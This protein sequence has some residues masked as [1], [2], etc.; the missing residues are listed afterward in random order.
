MVGPRRSHSRGRS[1]TG[2][3]RTSYKV[4]A[5]RPLPKGTVIT[6]KVPNPKK[7]TIKKVTK[8]PKIR[9][10]KT[11]HKNAGYH[12]IRETKVT[13]NKT[14]KRLG[15]PVYGTPSPSGKVTKEWHVRVNED[16]LIVYDWK[17][18]KYVNIGGKSSTA[19]K[20]A[21]LLNDYLKS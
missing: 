7:T 21:K 18:S 16:V 10:L 8:Q 2:S 12:L 14:R 17:G 9:N 5:N 11:P 3:S 20:N 1:R 13:V 15:K 19:K 6:V 4:S